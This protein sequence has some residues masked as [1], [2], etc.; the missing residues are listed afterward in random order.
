M[1]GVTDGKGAGEALGRALEIAAER[2]VGA[3]DVREGVAGAEV[4]DAMDAIDAMNGEPASVELGSN[5]SRRAPKRQT[6]LCVK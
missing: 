4:A 6:N 1:E 5:P 2:V 3:A